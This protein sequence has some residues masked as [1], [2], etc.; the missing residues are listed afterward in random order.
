MVSINH[1]LTLTSLSYL[2]YFITV[3]KY[4][5]AAEFLLYIYVTFYRFRYLLFIDLT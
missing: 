2:R 1:F 3:E 5:C 4:V